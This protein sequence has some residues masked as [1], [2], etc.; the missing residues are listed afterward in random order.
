MAVHGNPQWCHR[1]WQTVIDRDLNG[2]MLALRVFQTFVE[3]DQILREAGYDPETETKADGEKLNALIET[4]S[5]VCC[6]LG[7]EKMEELYKECVH[8]VQ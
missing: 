7:D 4:H 2:I 5:P 8:V 3:N 6:F 1:H